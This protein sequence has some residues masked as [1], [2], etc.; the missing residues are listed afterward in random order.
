M[1]GRVWLL[2]RVPP[3]GGCHAII[4]VPRRC[5]H[6]RRC[7]TR[8]IAWHPVNERL[9]CPRFRPGRA[10]RRPRPCVLCVFARDQRTALPDLERP[11]TVAPRA[12]LRPRDLCD[13][14]RFQELPAFLP[15]LPPLLWQD[16]GAARDPG[17]P[18]AFV[19][20]AVSLS[21]SV[22]GS[23]GILP[24]RS[25]VRSAGIL[26]A[27]SVVRS[28]GILPARSCGSGGSGGEEERGEWHECRE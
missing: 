19:R 9:C 15:R 22:A 11:E 3:P 8:R 24:A 25:V 2:R 16:A 10:N 27:R 1:S 28:A 18:G 26:P 13:R 5:L 14:V 20:Q 21:C 12:G 17:D 4:R 6:A 23:A 7:G